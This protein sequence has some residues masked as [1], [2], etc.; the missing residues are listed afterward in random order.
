MATFRIE[1]EDILMISLFVNACVVLQLFSSRAIE[2]LLRLLKGLSSKSRTLR[3]LDMDRPG[4]LGRVLVEHTSLWVLSVLAIATL[5]YTSLTTMP[6][7]H[8]PNPHPEF[9][10]SLTLCGNTARSLLIAVRIAL[11]RDVIFSKTDAKRMRKTHDQTGN[12]KL[13]FFYA[14][15]I[16]VSCLLCLGFKENLFLGI[17]SPLIELGATPLECCR[18][19]RM[20]KNHIGS[21]SYRKTS[22]LCFVM[23]VVSRLG[24]PILFFTLSLHQESPFV[25]GKVLVAWYFTSAIIYVVFNSLLLYQSVRRLWSSVKN[26]IPLPTSTHRPYPPPQPFSIYDYPEMLSNDIR[27]SEDCTKEDGQKAVTPW[28]K[29]CDYVFLRSYDNRNV[30][31]VLFGEEEEK[32]NAFKR[33]ETSK[34]T[35]LFKSRRPFE[36]ATD[37]LTPEPPLRKTSLSCDTIDSQQSD[38]LLESSDFLNVE[39]SGNAVSTV[40]FTSSEKQSLDTSNATQIVDN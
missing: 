6:F 5:N 28:Y 1:V 21:N 4:F 19:I 11:A 37:K 10:I 25:M 13:D 32:S 30:T 31:C 39:A 15:F 24:L 3:D 34:H 29:S 17:T 12:R 20:A 14:V 18:M 33:K 26:T 38:S 27:D 7:G 2:L 35:L 40:D 36:S 8:Q 16:A 22:I 9:L 23:T